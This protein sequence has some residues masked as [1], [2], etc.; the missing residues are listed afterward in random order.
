MRRIPNLCQCGTPPQADATQYLN[1]G[2]Q[3]FPGI[4]T[5]NLIHSGFL[6]V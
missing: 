6:L 3:Q 1:D 5:L 4:S 2:Q